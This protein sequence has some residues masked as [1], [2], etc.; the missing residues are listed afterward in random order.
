MLT[1]HPQWTQRRQ[2]QTAGFSLLELV[3]GMLVLAIGLTLLV[4]VL[5]PDADAV[6]RHPGTGP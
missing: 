2:D 4:S 1:T 3:V 6:G 5:L